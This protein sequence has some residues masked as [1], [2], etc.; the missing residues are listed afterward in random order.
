MAAAIRI[1]YVD[2]EPA[3]LDIGKIFL[4]HDGKFSVDTQTSAKT[5]LA[6]LNSVSY[7]AV[8]SDY[9][10]PGMDGIEFLKRV[11]AL[12]NTIP[13][14][15]FTGRGREEIVIQ[16][17]NEGADFYL[18]K[19]GDPE[20]QFAELA[21][22]I[23]RAIQQ[24]RAEKKLQES[25][26]R[27]KLL[28][29]ISHTGA[30]EYHRDGNYLWCSPEYFSMLGRKASQ[31]DMSGT[32]NLKETWLDLLHPDDRDRALEHFTQY[33]NTGSPGMY[34]SNFRMLHADGHWVWIWSRG[35]TMRDSNGVLTNRTIG[36]HIDVTEQRKTELALKE[37]ENQY[38]TIFDTTGAATIIID[39]DTMII[40]ANA[41]FALLSGYPLEEVE[42]KRSWTE[43]VVPEDLE[44]MKQY[45]RTRREDPVGETQIYDFKFINRNREIRHC[46]NN[47]RMIP[48]TTW[49]VASVVDIT[50]RKQ[51]EMSLQESE[52]K[53]RNVLENIQ[54]VFYRSDSEGRLVM[55]SPSWATLLGYDTLE[56]CLGQE[57][58][59]T[60]YYEPGKR[61][62]FLRQ[63]HEQGRVDNY[64]VTLKRKDGSPVLV[65][66]NSHLYYHKD[67]SVAGIE[68]LFRDITTLKKAE[69]QII[70]QAQILSNLNEIITAANRAKDLPELLKIF[71]DTTLR[72]LDYQA[73]GIYLV[74]PGRKTASV[75]HV[76]NLPEIFLSSISTVA[77]DQKPYD[78]LFVRG[79]PIIT[80]NYSEVSPSHS[81]ITGFQS[82]ASIPLIANER[83]IGALNVVSSKRDSVTDDE[84]TLLLS[85]G[86]ELGTTISRMAA[87]EQANLAREEW[88]RTFNAVPD[89]IAI[90][91]TNHTILRVN[92][93]MAE[94]LGVKPEQ[95]VGLTCY[96]CVHGRQNPPDFCPHSLLLRDQQE[97]TV[98]I[99]EERLGGDFVVSCTPLRDKEGRL[100]GS[101]H[102]AHDI[103]KR[104]QKE[105]ALIKN[106]EE[107]SAANEQIAAAEEELRANLD[108]LGRQELALRES[109]KKLADIIE[110][111][112][113]ATFAINTCGEVIAW[114]HA[115]EVMTGVKQADMLNK[116]NYEYS[117]PFYRE[118]RPI[119][120]DLVFGH[121]EA[122][123]K[124]YQGVRKE[125][126]RLIAEI[127]I[128]H[129][130]NGRGAYLW[131]TTSPLYD[132]Q[133][134]ITGA[135][136]SI[137]E[138]TEHK[139]RETALN[140]RNEELSAAYEEITSTEEELRQ[141]V[142]E[143][144]TTQQE[145]L[146]NEERY[147]NVVED[148][149]EFI[150]RFQPDG[151]HL[152]VNDAY[153]RYFGKNREDII[154]HFFIPNV[155][156]EDRSLLKDH[157]ASFTP[158]HLSHS[159]EHR[160]IMPDGEV[161]WQQWSDRAI[162]NEWGTVIEYQSVGRDITDN[163]RTEYALNQANIK[164]NLLSSI[165][166]H[167]INN[168]LTILQGYLK[169]LENRQPDPKLTEY[170]KGATDSVRQITAIIR[171]T[172]EYE[173]IGVH[174]PV[175]QDCRSLVDTA[176]KE[177]PLGKIMVKNDLPAGTEV[178]ADTLIV[179][180]FYNLVDNA[181]QYGGK[182]TTIR[183][184]VIES[185]DSHIIV[186][187]DDGSGVVSEEKEKIFDRG[188][189]KNTGLGL[190]LSREILDITGITIRET[191]EPG[192]GARFEMT[193][194]K[195]AWRIAGKNT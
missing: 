47:V 7:D 23:R 12:G 177:A 87:E 128:P 112:P 51:A 98:E 4:E 105:N 28:I 160:I 73:G 2:D 176:A 26:E 167:D 52:E 152:F 34:E 106:T 140:Q 93:A 131:F 175:W 15:L 133:G 91:D 138:I 181:V 115:M 109:R 184:S 95:A 37:S 137:R 30:W 110:F 187:E 29:T 72:L 150:C 147:R 162:F 71:L 132:S 83:I 68:G 97:H 182:I 195:G 158:D 122:V 104:K 76:K 63:V 118:R 16:A 81:R 145:L 123:A 1:L 58:A 121:D 178:F 44:R 36:T 14:I 164:L 40:K 139:E 49:S 165:T 143:I 113:D 61:S 27:Y 66:T 157:F 119:L 108:E 146:K 21:H 3:L 161:R 142:D 174:A 135:I 50:D 170:I 54:D 75:V 102:V 48:G 5:G 151:T 79:E 90:L 74:D 9:Q 62:E 180:V 64:I 116:G 41:E 80:E 65:S 144:V 13:F 192:K 191:G 33:L 136:E 43:F 111:L 155:P 11:R 100:L 129:L 55:A 6:L 168:K 39:N 78:L 94:K 42:G 185:D 69:E 117:L 82:L 173:K 169:I 8:V 19:G 120:I 24:K 189:G 179:K 86:R 32:S 56:E 57:I 124:K 17:L 130:H 18:Q 183:F 88:E 193:V 188:F 59:D 10:M 22:K 20:A 194:P 148:Q 154:N 125:G 141:Q 149:T 114:N 103:T 163:K 77:I 159:I 107:L 153:C 190:A 25:S 166:R 53:Y 101:V 70:Q 172:K 67:G 156:P 171:F 127:F 96:H 92:R 186:C 60:F 35:W 89:L 31:F 85:I 99:Y 84:R 45:H 46:I 126:D 38:R 134:K